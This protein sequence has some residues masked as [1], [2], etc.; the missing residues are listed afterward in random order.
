MH[1]TTLQTIKTKHRHPFQN[2]RCCAKKLYIKTLLKKYYEQ[3][4]DAFEHI[5]RPFFESA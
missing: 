5:F 4:P 2:A 3:E 1:N